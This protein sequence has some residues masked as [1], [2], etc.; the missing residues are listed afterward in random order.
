MHS[1]SYL[2]TTSLK[3]RLKLALLNQY[4]SKNPLMKGFHP[5]RADDRDYDCR[6]SFGSGTAN[7]HQSNE[8]SQT[9]GSTGE[10]IDSEFVE[11]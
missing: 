10:K 3:S 6:I 2:P 5:C 1:K 9:Y 11:I 4:N 8:Q 7:I